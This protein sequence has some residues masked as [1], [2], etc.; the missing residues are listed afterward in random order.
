[1]LKDTHTDTADDLEI[2][3]LKDIDAAVAEE[4]ITATELNKHKSLSY[5]GE[6]YRIWRC[7]GV[8]IGVRIHKQRP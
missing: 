7:N 1:M 3:V 8:P 5:Q 2:Q 4:V 6:G